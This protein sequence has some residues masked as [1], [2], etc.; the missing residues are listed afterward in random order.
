MEPILG[1]QAPRM[2]RSA[3]AAFNN[4]GVRVRLV[5]RR[6]REELDQPAPWNWPGNLCHGHLPGVVGLV[7]SQGGEKTNEA[8]CSLEVGGK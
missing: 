7:C 1:I 4:S 2:V 3:Y 5:C 8:S 6:S